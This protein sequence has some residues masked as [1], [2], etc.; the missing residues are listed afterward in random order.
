MMPTLHEMGDIVAVDALTVNSGLRP[1]SRGDIIIA[2]A[3]GRGP[4]AGGEGA[5]GEDYQVCKRIIALEG[6][7]IQPVGSAVPLRVPAGH[8]W[9]EGDNPHNSV[10]SRFYGPLPTALIRGRVLCRVWPFHRARSLVPELGSGAAASGT[11]AVAASDAD[12]SS[13]ASDSDWM[14][15]GASMPFKPP[16]NEVMLRRM[17]EDEAIMS[18]A[19]ATLQEARRRLA[20]RAARMA[21]IEAQQE[22]KSKQQHADAHAAREGEGASSAHVEAHDTE[23][24]A[25]TAA[26]VVHAHADAPLAPG[27]NHHH[28]YH[29]DGMHP[30]PESEVSISM[31]DAYALASELSSLD[32]SEFAHDAPL[33]PADAAGPGSTVAAAQYADALR[34]AAASRVASDSEAAAS[35]AP[36]GS[37]NELR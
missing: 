30:H 31:E 33:L 13:E 11:M 25:S 17:L 14:M 37:S 34:A 16:S 18:D 26:A 3:P 23:A 27:S 29:H 7:L 32:T 2:N 4:H 36:S 6:D 20:E 5:T 28:D 1:L 15:Q 19:R 10:D 22:A 12:S 35:A 24:S 9:V 8:V 21:Q